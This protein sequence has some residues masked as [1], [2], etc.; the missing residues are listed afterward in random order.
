M[1]IR[2]TKQGPSLAS[3]REAAI[4]PVQGQSS[5]IAV[6]AQPQGDARGPWSS[7][8]QPQGSTC[9]CR[10]ACGGPYTNPPGG[11]AREAAAAT[12]TELGGAGAPPRP[13]QAAPTPPSTDSRQRP[14]AGW[15]RPGRRSAAG[16][17][18]GIAVCLS[19]PA[20]RFVAAHR[21]ETVE[22]S[23]A[24]LG[25]WNIH[26]SGGGLCWRPEEEHQPQRSS[27]G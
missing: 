6:G 20:P 14:G 4:C 3:S 21:T 12:S 27:A 19:L 13:R 23:S 5:F 1:Q 17:R 15:R 22:P 8:D 11:R 25:E 9:S 10:A 16:G 7:A 24:G 18:S 26:N 2:G